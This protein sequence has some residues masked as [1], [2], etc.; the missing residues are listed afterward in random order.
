MNPRRVRFTTTARRH[1]R[2][3]KE[4][5][6]ENRIHA[7]VFVA[8]FEESPPDLGLV[9]RRRDVLHAGWCGW[10]SPHLR[11]ESRPAIS[12]T[13]STNA[14]LLSVRS[15]APAAVAVLDYDLESCRFLLSAQLFVDISDDRNHGHAGTHSIFPNRS[16]PADSN[17]TKETGP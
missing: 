5:W 8:E 1:V 4:W 2:H 7:D 3:E 16:A 17:R 9:A 11:S 12:T 10:P 15:G 6:L 14:R 13:R